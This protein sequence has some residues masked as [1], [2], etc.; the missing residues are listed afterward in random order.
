L[1]TK[2]ARHVIIDAAVEKAVGQPEDNKNEGMDQ[3]NG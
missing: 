3:E 2:G 1:W